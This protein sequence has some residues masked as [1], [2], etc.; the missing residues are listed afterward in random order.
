MRRFSIIKPPR[1]RKGD[2]IGVISPAG[3]VDSAEL[4][5]GLALLESSGFGVRLPEHVY[6]RK[7]Y[8]AGE[9]QS[10]LHDFHVMFEDSDIKAVICARGGYGSMRLLD[11]INFDLVRRNPKIFVGYS[12]ITALHMAIW[13]KTGLV[14]FHGPMVRELPGKDESNWNRLERLLSSP[15]AFNLE[16]KGAEVLVPGWAEGRLVGGNLSLVCHLMGT[17][18]L[19]SLQGCLLFLE[20]K[21]E[22]MYRIDRMLTHLLLSGQLR[23]VAGLMAG[24]FEGCGEEGAVSRLLEERFARLGVPIVAGLPVGHGREN[25]ALPIGPIAQID[26]D[27]MTLSIPESCVTDE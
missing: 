26:T 19:P 21:G 11:R 14:S 5:S 9:D 6:D 8:L 15:E 10:R 13:G 27:Q 4:Q 20:E 2:L 25:V 24:G 23:G 7:D 12:D 3:P 18:F 22:P 1:L 16:L 17:P